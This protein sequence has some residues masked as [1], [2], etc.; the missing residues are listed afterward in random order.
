MSTIEQKIENIGKIIERHLRH[1]EDRDKEIAKSLSNR[2]TK[3][4][5]IF[6]KLDKIS[7]ELTKKVNK[8]DIKET[9]D[10][11]DRLESFADRCKGVILFLGVVWTAVVSWL[12]FGAKS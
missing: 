11:L 7:D 1:D 5:E 3:D 4:S 12:G 2:E 6:N 9:V 10:R 8:E